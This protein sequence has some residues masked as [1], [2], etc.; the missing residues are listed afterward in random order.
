MSL[1]LTPSFLLNNFKV[2]TPCPA[3]TKQRMADLIYVNIYY[4]LQT[5][6]QERL[7]LPVKCVQSKHFKLVKGLAVQTC[8]L[9]GTVRYTTLRVN[10]LWDACSTVSLLPNVCDTPLLYLTTCLWH[11]QHMLL[12]HIEGFWPEWWISTIYQAWDTPFWSGILDLSH[13]CNCLLVTLVWDVLSNSLQLR[14]DNTIKL[15]QTMDKS[16]SISQW[17]L[18]KTFSITLW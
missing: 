7:P 14:Y 15:C 3:M 5:N 13:L 6:T 2:Q 18:A 16:S 11:D 17:H 8:S 9:C 1:L 12:P 10:I 4:Y